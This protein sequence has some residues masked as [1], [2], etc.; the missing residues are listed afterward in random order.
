M[1][2]KHFIAVLLLMMA[3]LQTAKAQTMTLNFADGTKY[4]YGVSEIESVTFSDNGGAIAGRE[5]VDLGLPSGT[6]WATCNVGAN[7][8]EEYGDYFAW[9]ETEPKEVYDF[10]SY[11][12]GTST[13]L[14]KYCTTSSSSYRIDWL[15]TLLAEDDAATANW[16]KNW[17]TPTEEQ[18]IELA[19]TD[20]T[21]IETTTLNEVAGSL[22]TSK[23][24]GKSIFLPAT[25]RING[26]NHIGVGSQGYYWS[27]SLYENLCNNG[28]CVR[29][30]SSIGRTQ[31]SR[32]MGLS[33]RPVCAKIKTEV[34]ESVDL[35]LPSGTL[36]ATCNVGA[37]SPE[38]RGTYFAWSETEPKLIYDWNHYQ[39][40]NPATDGMTKYNVVGGVVGLEPEDDAATVNWGED[41]KM[42]DQLQMAE[43]I[44]N[45]TQTWQ[46]LDG[47]YGYLFTSKVNENSIFMPLTGVRWDDN[48]DGFAQGYYW[49]NTLTPSNPK[50]SYYMLLQP[51]NTKPT[52]NVLERYLGACVRPVKKNAQPEHEYVDL[53]LPSGTLWATCNI[54]A[55]NPEDYGDYFAW[56]ETDPERRDYYNWETYLLCEGTSETITK[57][58]AT[59][60]AMELLPEDDAATVNWGS[61]WQMPSKEQFNE[62]LNDDL[63]TRTTTTLNGVTGLEI[64]SKSNGKS[65]FLP[66]AGYLRESGSL[67]FGNQYGLYWS[68]S[69]CA[70]DRYWFA[71]RLYFTFSIGTSDIWRFY[72]QSVRPV[73]K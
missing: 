50:L 16:G 60:E 38:E 2:L 29:V 8:P 35:G 67:E 7:S 10:D 64:T 1:K 17:R 51:S 32:N 62:L 49:S 31:S 23:I 56:G 53:A 61:N 48:L 27:S 68:R 41:W 42:P 70:D 24:N 25:G 11:K 9:G 65:I 72:A 57:Y 46:K 30:G 58:N 6:L 45:T 28:K 33:V 3:G 26:S 19:N 40:Y 59:D 18:L 36:W 5:Y 52:T 13:S 4:V 47:V 21:V 34:R 55:E 71:G 22:I 44:N 15:V 20:Y 39:Y 12:W 63:T 69:R 66:A 73:R 14:Q 54:G 43:L 37:N